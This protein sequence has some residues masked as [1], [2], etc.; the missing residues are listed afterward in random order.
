MQRHYI[1][2]TAATLLGVSLIIVTAVHISGKAAT[3]LA[4]EISFAAALSFL[5][6]CAISHRAIAKADDRFERVA[7]RFFGTGLLLLLCGALSFWF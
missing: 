1:I 7:D 3:S 4:D 2:D 5:G 6:A